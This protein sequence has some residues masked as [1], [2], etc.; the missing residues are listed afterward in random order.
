[1]LL[2]NVWLCFN[3]F[4]TIFA[5][6]D[7][8]GKVLFKEQAESLVS[9][10]LLNLS[11][12]PL[13]SVW[14]SFKIIKKKK[15]SK[16]NR[17]Q[18]LKNKFWQMNCFSVEQKNWRPFSYYFYLGLLLERTSVLQLS[19]SLVLSNLE[20]LMCGEKRTLFYSWNG[21]DFWMRIILMCL[22]FFFVC[23]FVC[24]ILNILCS[25]FQWQC[26][27]GNNLEI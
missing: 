20:L 16:A 11:I 8:K 25:F 19:S 5:C 22:G 12:Y 9:Y 17:W 10:V 14:L 1:M 13:Q 6:T 21:V 26:H 7:W 4:I 2:R 3:N 23:F 24:F 18:V 15:K 27:T